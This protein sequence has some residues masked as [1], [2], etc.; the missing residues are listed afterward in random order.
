MRARRGKTRRAYCLTGY[1]KA[2]VEAHLDLVH[3]VLKRK[4]CG[5]SRNMHRL[6]DDLVQAGREGLIDAVAYYDPNRGHALAAYAPKR[7]WGAC[8]E[9]LRGRRAMTPKRDGRRVKVDDRPRVH[10]MFSRAAPGSDAFLVNLGSGDAV[11]AH[12]P[13]DPAPPVGAAMEA[14]EDFA[15]WTVGLDDRD[16]FLVER[17]Y[18]DDPWTMKRIGA[19]L[20]LSESRVSQRHAAVLDR[21]RDRPRGPEYRELATAQEMHR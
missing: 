4:R 15:A 2:E 17:Y 7:I 11:H 8:Q 6:H 12:F 18:G 1:G 10:S 19:H 20:G 3:F 16:R 5:R 9:F 21:L 13:P 14:A